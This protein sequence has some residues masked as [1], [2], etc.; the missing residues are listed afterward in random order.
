MLFDSTGLGFTIRDGQILVH[1]PT[2]RT[3][4][5]GNASDDGEGRESHG[6]GTPIGPIPEWYTFD[7][8]NDITAE[9]VRL[10]Q[11]LRQ[12]AD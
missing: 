1:Y 3:A 12:L 2:R 9:R 8:P 7:P 5:S 6:T 11:E 10:W 4:A